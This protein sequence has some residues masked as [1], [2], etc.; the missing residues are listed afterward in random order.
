[1]DPT[2]L[3]APAP[4]NIVEML[5]RHVCEPV[6]WRDGI[7]GLLAQFADAQLIEVGMMRAWLTDWGESTTSRE[8]AMGWMSGHGGDGIPVASMRMTISGLLVVRKI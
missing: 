6:R 7:D 8:T 2:P 3:E 4:E 1:M 5:S